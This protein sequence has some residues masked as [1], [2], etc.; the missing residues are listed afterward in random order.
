MTELCCSEVYYCP[1]VRSHECATHGGFDV[2]CEH[3][4]LHD[5]LPADIGTVRWWGQDWGAPACDPRAHVPTPAGH[6]CSYCPELIR[7]GDQGITVPHMPFPPDTRTTSQWH[8]E[9]W[10]AHLGVPA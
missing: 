3:P 5:P 2:C 7:D 8:L 6:A 9:C 10:L 4:E 1:T